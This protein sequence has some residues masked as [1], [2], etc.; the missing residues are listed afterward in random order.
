MEQVLLWFSL[1]VG[2]VLFLCRFLPHRAGTEAAATTIQTADVALHPALRNVALLAPF[3]GFFL[4]LPSAG[5][6]LF[7]DGQRLG[8]GFLIGGIA[9]LLSCVDLLSPRSPNKTPTTTTSSVLLT[10]S[11]GM[12]IVAVVLALMFLRQSLFDGLMGVAIGGFCVTFVLFLAATGTTQRDSATDRRLVAATGMMATLAAA[13]SLGV[14]R[15]P[16]TPELSKLTW[17]AVLTAFAAIGT[18]LVAGTALLGVGQSGKIGRIIPLTVLVSVGGLA[19]YQ[20]ATKLTNTAELSL[21]GIGG[22]LLWPVALSVLREAQHRGGNTTATPLLS[23]PLLAV[24]VVTS[25]FLAALQSLQGVGVAV[26]TLA[27][28]VAYPAT[29][30]L[31][32]RTEEE[33]EG[34]SAAAISNG[35]VGLL[36]FGTLLLLWRLFATRWAGDLRGVNITDQYALFGLL[37]GAALPGLLAAIPRRIREQKTMQSG[38]ALTAIT[39]CAILSV[40]APAA[41]LTL[42]GAK[43]AVALMIGLALGAVPVLTGGTSLLPGLLALAVSLALTQF[44]GAILPAETPT[45]AEKIRYLAVIMSAI[46]VAVILGGRIGTRGEKD[47]TETK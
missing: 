20:M 34:N 7:H 13:A 43:S 27:L 15:D 42:F 30:M 23:V 1:T 9:T 28:F 24:L 39:I 17:S 37:V 12:G 16:L 8:L 38:G 47:G 5:G 19:L 2:V 41:V 36:L 21:I 14:F 18:L 26:G 35:A 45:R 4:T 33:A 32:D 40:A 31:S 10:S 25:G 44:T 46:V 3:V 29:L 22:L 11:Y 6:N